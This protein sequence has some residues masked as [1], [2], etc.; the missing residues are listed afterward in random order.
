MPNFIDLTGQKFNRLTVIDR[1]PN[2]TKGTMWNCLCDCKSTSVVSAGNLKNGHT[3]SCGCFRE[4]TTG[5][6]NRSHNMSFSPEHNALAEMKRRCTKKDRDTWDRY[7][8]RGIT[9]CDR[10][11]GRDGLIHFVEDMGYKP[12]RKHSIGRRDNDG[13]YTP[14]NCHWETQKQQMNN[15]SR[16]HPITFVGVTMNICQWADFLHIK[17]TTLLMRINRYNWP[18]A[19]ALLTPVTHNFSSHS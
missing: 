17:R 10:W 8:G 5:N 15:M 1:A 13:N 2:K 6:L 19:K 9:V 7:G 18:V 14:E 3:T 16:N 12:S 11:L 4:E